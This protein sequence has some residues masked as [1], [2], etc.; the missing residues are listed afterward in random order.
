MLRVIGVDRDLVR[1]VPPGLGKFIF[2]EQNGVVIAVQFTEKAHQQC[3]GKRPRLT[4]VIPQ[5]FDRQT[6]LAPGR[7]VIEVAAENGPGCAAF[8]AAVEVTY[9]D[10]RIVRLPTGVRGWKASLEGGPFGEPSV[11]GPYGCRPYGKFEGKGM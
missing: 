8:I 4:L 1:A 10:G 9:A 7:N 11:V 5:V 2:F 6:N 3:V